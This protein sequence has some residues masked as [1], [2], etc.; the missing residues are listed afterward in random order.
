[1]NR[2]DFIKDTAAATLSLAALT[3]AAEEVQAQATKPAYDDRPTGATVNVGVI[4][5]G[6]QGR[7]ILDTLPRLGILPAVAICDNYAPFLNRSKNAAPK[8]VAYDDYRKLLD[9]KNVQAVIVATPTHQHK[10]IVLDALQ[11]GKHVFCE[12]PIA[13]TVEDAK[14][15]ALAGKNAAPKLVFQAGLQNR[16]H[17]QYRHVDNFVRSGVL[18][19]VATARAQWHQKTSWRKS[20]STPEQEKELNWRISRETSPG[21][22]GEVGIHSLD[23]ANWFLKALPVSAIGFGSII[24]WNDGRD[25]PDTV[26]AI[27]EYPKGARMVYDATLANSFDDTYNVFQGTNASV[28]IRGERAW[29]INEADATQDGW[30]V[31]AKKEK[32]NNNVGITLVADATKLLAL[33]KEPGKDGFID[34][35]KTLLYYALESFLKSVQAGTPSD[36]GPLVG[37]QAAVTAIKVNEAVVSGTRIEFNKEWFDL[38]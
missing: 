31:Y 9:D 21:L 24:K 22:I 37:Y 28:F 18:G 17:P 3:A 7:E 2:R 11:A 5:L 6:A 10:Q 27:I 12:A 20:S 29:M 8:A 4:G 34:P 13:H 14:A 36:A 33:G 32:I 38:A 19:K 26:Q 30:I 25:V 35:G 15:I 23:A 1:M 16:V